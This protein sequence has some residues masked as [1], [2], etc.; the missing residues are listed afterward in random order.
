[1]VKYD[2]EKVQ[3][4]K[5]PT[6]FIRGDDRIAKANPGIINQKYY[7]KF[8]HAL[9]KE[10]SYYTVSSVKE[11]SDYLTQF[12]KSLNDT[13]IVYCHDPSLKDSSNLR[14]AFRLMRQESKR[15]I[16]VVEDAKLSEGMKME[17]GKF[18]VYYKPSFINGFE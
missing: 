15:P 11:L 8:S 6:V 9:Q 16:L 10:S 14:T 3:T 13:T 12:N 7:K 1:M 18:Y 4:K 17:A 2:Q 5:R